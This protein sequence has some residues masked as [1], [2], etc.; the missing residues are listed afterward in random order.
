MKQMFT[1]QVQRADNGFIAIC[2]NDEP[3]VKQQKKV[4]TSEKDV[5]A[6]VKDFTDH[7]FDVPP[8]KEEPK[9]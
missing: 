1:I 2:Q 6:A 8:Q 4:A 7:M 9:P 5:I 3:G